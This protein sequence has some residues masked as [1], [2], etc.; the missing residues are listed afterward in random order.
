MT[1]DNY[2]ESELF[3]ND[4]KLIVSQDILHP[5]LLIT[6]SIVII[7]SVVGN[8]LILF[9]LFC[10]KNLRSVLGL[11]IGSLA[12]SD[13]LAAALVMPMDI[14]G[15][16]CGLL[17][18]KYFCLVRSG[19]FIALFGVTVLNLMV[20]SV[21]RFFA[22]AYPLKHMSYM[23]R[24]T[25][26]TYWT[27]LFIWLSMTVVGFA[28]LLGW[29]TFVS[30]SICAITD[31]Y[32]A[33]HQLLFTIVYALGTVINMGFLIAVIS[34]VVFKLQNS[35]FNA[36]FRQSRNLKKTVLVLMI[37]GWFVVCWGPYCVITFARLLTANISETVSRWCLLPAA[38]NTGFNWMIYGFGNL[39]IRRAMFSIIRCKRQSLSINSYSIS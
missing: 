10:F 30:N 14:I 19:G 26:V 1:T 32:T 31:I 25:T 4:T 7:P 37:S 9:S 5:V 28:P 29:N 15:Q 17:R 11:L 24:M 38:M 39:K 23:S 12:F 2:E 16:S 36:N 6:E 8:S 22:L 27:M 13:L 34:L 18:N 33:E 20:I 35:P 3:H 21:E